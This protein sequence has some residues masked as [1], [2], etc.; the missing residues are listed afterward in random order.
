M[1]VCYD[2]QTHRDPEQISRLVRTLLSESPGAV[3]H[4][5]HDRRGPELDE[6]ALQA[7]GDVVVESADGG[8]GD[9]SHVDRHMQAINW[10]LEHRPDVDWLVNITG[11]DYP[12]VPI[13]A[14]EHELASSDADAF[15]E[16]HPGFGEGSR[17]PAHRVRSRYYFQHRR[18]KSLTPKWRNRLHPLQALNFAQPLV[19]F[20]V[21][22]GVM[23]GRRARTPFSATFPVYGGSAFMSLRRPVL[24]YLRD[25]YIEH[26]DI[27]EY[28]RH[29]L[30]PVEAV[31]PT[32]LANAGKFTLVNDC[33]R[34]FDFRGSSFNHPKL[35]T[36]DDLPLAYASGAHF[37][38]KID[39]SDP[40][41]FDVI[42]EHRDALRR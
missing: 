33:K 30:S 12:I 39:F 36:R 20:H 16:F 32:V 7:Y 22:Y 9:F 19:R 41:I 21:A 1:R 10:V 18:V 24:E 42:D 4:I 2:I 13:T 38:R 3:V 5:S 17:W 11:Q 27:M 14:V 40:S 34:Y 26:P 6:H 8:Y 23:L 29:T 37:A 25:F 28:F 31:F 35:L 15:L